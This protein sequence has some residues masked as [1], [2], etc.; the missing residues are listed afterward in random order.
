[1]WK[2]ISRI[3]I[4]FTH[5]ENLFQNRSMG[6]NSIDNLTKSEKEAIQLVAK[7]NVRARSHSAIAIAMVFSKTYEHSHTAIVFATRSFVYMS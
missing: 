4:Y 3:C 6:L 5:M 1:M 7:L 2:G